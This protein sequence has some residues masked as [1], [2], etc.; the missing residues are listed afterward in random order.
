MR[1]SSFDRGPSSLGLYQM[2]GCRYAVAIKSSSSTFRSPIIVRCFSYSWYT[3][4]R[5]KLR[6]AKAS[7]D[8][9]SKEYLPGKPRMDT[10]SR[11]MS[12]TSLSGR[13]LAGWE[14]MHTPQ[15]LAQQRAG[16]LLELGGGVG[17]RRCNATR[18][19]RGQAPPDIAFISSF[20]H[21]FKNAIP[22]RISTLGPS[23]R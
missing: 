23:L 21:S 8:S 2:D 14:G 11:K 4:F 15:R 6:T 20:E 10:N 5:E 16:M 12:S 19:C 13:C 1:S 9:A 17:A 7:L 18:A 22:K 3:V